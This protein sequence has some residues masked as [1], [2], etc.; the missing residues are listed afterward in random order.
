MAFFGPSV[1]PSPSSSSSPDTFSPIFFKLLLLVPQ[2]NLVYVFLMVQALW[3]FGFWPHFR[4]KKSRPPYKLSIFLWFP[5]QNFFIYHWYPNET[6]YTCSLLTWLYDV[7]VFYP[8][9]EKK[10]ISPPM[11]LA[12]LC[13]FPTKFFSSSLVSQWNMIYTCSLSTWLYEVLVFDP[14]LEK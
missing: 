11:D 10:I 4:K 7:L 14:I 12:F 3:R 2:W 5:P 1:R 13:G 9:F 8:N 6:W